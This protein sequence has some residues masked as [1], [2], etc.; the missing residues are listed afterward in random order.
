[1]VGRHRR[2]A[3]PT[4]IDDVRQLVGHVDAE[5][6]VPAVVEPVLK[7]VRGVLF[8]HVDVEFALPGEP[9]ERQVTAAHSKAPKVV[10][11]TRH[12]V[13]HLGYDH[14]GRHSAERSQVRS[15]RLGPLV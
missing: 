11:P 1:M 13:E 3:R 15:H 8:E 10:T 5:G 14:L 6:V 2:L 4:L 9:R 12:V 7:L